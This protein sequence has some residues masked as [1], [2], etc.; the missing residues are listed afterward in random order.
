MRGSARSRGAAAL[1]VA[2]ALLLPLSGSAQS[3]ANPPPRPFDYDFT[4][5]AE[6][7]ARIDPTSPDSEMLREIYATRR[8]RVLQAIP[9]GAMLVFSVEW[10]QPRR[11]EFQVPDSDNHDFVFLTGLDGLESVGSALLLLPSD[12]EGEDWVVLFTPE[13]PARIRALTGIHDVRP[14]QELEEALSV[15]MTDYRD[16]RITQIRRWPLP[17]ALSRKWGRAKTALYLN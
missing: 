8:H 11:L 4:E 2:T 13:D 1:V 17:A 14:Y 15:A 6:L 10:V 16:W 12:G 9:D 7:A 5:E 3:R